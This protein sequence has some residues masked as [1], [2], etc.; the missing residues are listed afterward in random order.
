MPGL[1]RLP[2]MITVVRPEAGYG[3]WGRVAHEPGPRRLGFAFAP[4]GGCS[5]HPCNSCRLVHRVS[6]DNGQCKPIIPLKTPSLFFFLLLLAHGTHSTPR[7]RRLGAPA[8][9]GR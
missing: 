6:L 3:F 8:S 9:G 7:P 4:L 1:A 5:T 2:S